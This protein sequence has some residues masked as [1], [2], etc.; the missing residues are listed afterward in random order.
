MSAPVRSVTCYASGARTTSP[1]AMT[2]KSSGGNRGISVIVDTTVVPA[3]APS[4]VVTIQ[5]YDP[6]SG[7]YHTLLSS[8]P[9]TAVGTVVLKVYPGLL[10][11]LLPTNGILAKGTLAIDTAAE[12]FKTTTTL[13]YVIN[14]VV[15]TKVA[16][17]A[18]VFSAAH[19]VAAT[20]YGI[21]LV[22][23]NAA[24]TITTKVPGATL[25]TPM[26]YASAGAALA[27]LPTA[28]SDNVAIGYITLDNSTS[29]GT[30]AAG[31]WVAITD[32]L[33]D[34]GDI[35]DSGFVDATETTLTAGSNTSVNNVLPPLW[36]VIV[37]AGNANS[38]TYS[39]G[40]N[41]LP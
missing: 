11:S 7:K 37:T 8:D 36:R 30:G 23:I 17:T 16:T 18:L 5:G 40:A 6:L 27:A 20:K 34:T 4:N 28:D 13:I 10:P 41:L 15:Y 24:G 38:A 19:V 21:A 26:T 2:N 9:I 33:T 29:Q 39:V 22:Q 35:T 1:T 12:K 32:D 31:A 3:G 14:N 25:T